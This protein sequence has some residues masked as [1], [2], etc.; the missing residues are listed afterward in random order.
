VPTVSACSSVAAG[1]I[2]LRR[3]AGIG[4]TAQEWR[5]V[6]AGEQEGRE[7]QAALQQALRR[8]VNERRWGGCGEAEVV[9]L[10]CECAETSCHEVVLL[11]CEEYE[12]IRRV[13]IRLIV[14]PDHVQLDRERVLIE[15]PGRFAVVEKF[16]PAREVV[17]HLDPR[18]RG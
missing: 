13:P 2:V 12:F 7:R 8:E 10:V 15:E 3:L 9:E 6:E 5:S 18:G 17:A 1:S 4:C 16:G 11:S 14:R